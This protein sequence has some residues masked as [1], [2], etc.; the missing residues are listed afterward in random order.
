MQ[1]IW[2]DWENLV[3]FGMLNLRKQ[4]NGLILS[5]F[6]DLMSGQNSAFENVSPINESQWA[7]V[8]TA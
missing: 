8:G 1:G 3:G 6:P 4:K 5:S 7:R 2:G